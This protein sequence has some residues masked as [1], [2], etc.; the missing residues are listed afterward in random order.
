MVGHDDAHLVYRR[1]S[2]MTRADE[3]ILR[4]LCDHSKIA[5]NPSTIAFNTEYSNSYAARRLRALSDHGLVENV[6]GN[7]PM[8]KITELGVRY[9]EGD[10][11]LDELE[12]KDSE[13]A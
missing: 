10:A 5:M 11:E 3:F 9:V 2:W 12:E 13:T 8:F 7:G 1:V 4:L 6:G